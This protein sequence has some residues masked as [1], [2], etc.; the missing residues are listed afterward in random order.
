MLSTSPDTSYLNSVGLSLP[1][2]RTTQNETKQHPPS[3]SEP[4]TVNS[5]PSSSPP[6]ILP[7]LTS[8]YLQGVDISLSSQAPQRT[9]TKLSDHVG[10]AIETNNEIPWTTYLEWFVEGMIVPG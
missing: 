6:S 1:S 4:E 9:L 10:E 7:L 5:Q 8:P 2:S 3:N